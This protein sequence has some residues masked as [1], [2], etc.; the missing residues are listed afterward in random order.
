MKSGGV[1]SVQ[2]AQKLAEPSMSEGSVIL[3][4]PY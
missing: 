3:I 1:D 4:G 2:V